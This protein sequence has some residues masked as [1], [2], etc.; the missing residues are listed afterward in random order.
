M[1]CQPDDITIT[2]PEGPVLPGIPGLG[3]PFTPS[4][5]DSL[6][7]IPDGFP[8]DL[9]DLFRKLSMILPPGTIKPGLT[10]SFSKDIFDGILS[11]LDKFFPFLMA[12]KFFLPILN[13]IICI[14]E[15]LC[16]IPN[17]FKLSR[18]IIRLFR[19]CIPEFLSLFPIFALILMLIS[20]LLLL[21]A[22]I[23]YIILQLLKIIQSILRNI[24]MLVKA[25][26]KADE[27]SILSIV[28][29]IGMILCG[30][31][32]LFVVLAI[33]SAIIQVIKDIL[34]LIFN[35]P[36]C[37]DADD[38]DTEG[39][40]TNDVC[41]RFIRENG[42]M[43]RF[44]GT[45][46]Y[47]PA[48]YASSSLFTSPPF[49]SLFSLNIRNE[50]H[51]FFDA[52]ATTYQQFIN[53]TD[54][55]DITNIFPQP[56]P[57]FFP[58]DSNYTA[59]T[60]PGQ[61]P[62]VVDLRL[63]YNP[64]D[65]GRSAPPLVTTI[66]TDNKTTIFENGINTLQKPFVST[67]NLKFQ[68]VNPTTHEVV[69]SGTDGVITSGTSK[70]NSSLVNFQNIPGIT[71]YK[72][73]IDDPFNEGNRGG[74]NIISVDNSNELTISKPAF[75]PKS[76]VGRFIRFKN[77]IVKYA[78]TTSLLNYDNTSIN[79]PTGVLTLV[80]G[81]GTEDDGSA[82]YGYEID[83][84]TQSSQIATLENFLFRPAV[85]KENPTLSP[86]DPEMSG[87]TIKNVEYTFRIHYDVLLRKSLIT[88]GCLPEVKLNKNFVNEIFANNSSFKYSALV[89]A[90]NGTDGN[91]FPDVAGLQDC[92]SIAL[93]AF[94][95][96]MSEEGAAIFQA[97][98]IA[99]LEKAKQDTHAA[100]TNIIGIGF[101]PC[102]STFT[103][104][105]DTQF[106]GKPINVQVQLN[107]SNGVSIADNLPP[108][109]Y[110]N[111]ESRLSAIFTFGKISGFKYDGTRYFNLQ[112]NSDVAG[113]GTIQIAF[114]NQ[115]FCDVNIPSDINQ[116]PTN[117]LRELPYKFVFVP[118]LKSDLPIDTGEGDIDGAPRRD[119]HDVSRDKEG[120]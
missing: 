38:T 102:K 12:Y 63:F 55:A 35:I 83:G 42:E 100:L 57:V 31:Q 68:I 106:T 116:P 119:E 11:L 74:F 91:I 43:K 118:T 103:L 77:C 96:N 92:M 70:F 49:S 48:V 34:K 45:L 115:I 16:S 85:R 88:L 47:Y 10:P 97:T 111:L 81:T 120:S 19:N 22:I 109:V 17:P 80:G 84:K 101:D 65:W 114:D 29:K 76:I 105:P 7:K 67:F 66:T 89:A 25:I 69:A 6:F 110:S 113:S 73:V 36:P 107:E 60:P 75:N 64:E 46:Q 62:Y 117:K 104:T 2:E 54:A 86:F 59:S 9:L 24:R 44:T 4:L 61:V 87:R 58:T 71:G 23:E 15:V 72:I 52:E 50:S 20:L 82:L 78:P 99:C 90:I 98:C 40:C 95:K 13:L 41:P 79:I 37:D 14:I 30:F 53:I 51:Q 1:P 108:E 26:R 8:E 112:I 21:L 32:N 5:P 28:K 94:R 56:K 93:D 33:I 18:A 27:Q 39:C 3:S